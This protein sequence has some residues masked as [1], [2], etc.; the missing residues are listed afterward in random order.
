MFYSEVTAK[1][2]VGFLELVLAGTGG[3]GSL[4]IS[5]KSTAV[6]KPTLV[7]NWTSFGKVL[8]ELHVVLR[9]I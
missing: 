8:T 7:G 6:L 5:I 3:G 4:Y 1:K 2:V 9:I